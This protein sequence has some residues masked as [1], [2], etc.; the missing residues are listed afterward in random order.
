MIRNG[1]L[2]VNEEVRDFQIAFSAG[3]MKYIPPLGADDIKI[4]FV[5]IF[6][7]LT[8]VLPLR[9]LLNE[10]F[11]FLQ[12]TALFD[13][14]TETV[15]GFGVVMRL[16]HLLSDCVTHYAQFLEILGVV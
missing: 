3:G 5:S 10:V 9:E 4:E 13:L 12:C 15:Y 14:V 16:Q 6:K 7:T 2:F 11:E 1:L 8:I